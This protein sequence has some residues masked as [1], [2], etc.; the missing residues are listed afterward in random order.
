MFDD[1]DALNF[2]DNRS[3]MKVTLTFLARNFD[4]S[5]SFRFTQHDMTADFSR[6]GLNQVVFEGEN[7]IMRRPNYFNGTDWAY[8]QTSFMGGPRMDKDMSMQMR[9]GTELFVLGYS[10]GERHRSSGT[11]EPYFSTA[12]VA[13]SGIENGVIQVTE[14]GWDGGNSGGPVYVLVNGV[15]TVIGL[16][17]G[18]YVRT[19]GSAMGDEVYIAGSI[20]VV[21]PLGNMR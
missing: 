13:L 20:K 16:V 8:M 1:V 7:G 4:N 19:V 18:A 17:T 14:A 12:K 10:Y 3:D 5:V 9:N 21:T 2:Y 11:L 6:D 15:P